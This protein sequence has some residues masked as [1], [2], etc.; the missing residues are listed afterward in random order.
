MLAPVAGLPADIRPTVGFDGSQAAA[1]SVLSSDPDLHL[2]RRATFGQTP[3]VVADIRSQG[4]TAWLDRQLNPSQIDDSAMNSLLA[5]FPMISASLAVLN[6]QTQPRLGALELVQATLARQIWSKRQLFEIMVDFW[7][8][9]LNVHT[10]ESATH[11]TKPIEDRTVTRV[12]AL[13]RFEDLLVASGRSPAML[14]YLDNADSKL[15]NPNENYGRELLQL[16]TVGAGANFTEVDV[17]NSARILTGRSVDATNTFVYKPDWHFVG[18][19]SVLGWSSS[20]ASAS[21]GLSTGDSY[22]RYL[23]RH[24][25]TARSLS[26]KLAIRFVSDTPPG[27]LVD[28]LTDVYLESGTAIVPW[29][30]ALFQS[31]EFAASTGQKMRRPL[32]DI[33]ASVRAMKLGV[34]TGND[35]SGIKLLVT[36]SAKFG[37]QPLDCGPP[38]GYPDVAAG[39]WA[40]GGMLSRCNWHRIVSRV[41]PPGL[42]RPPLNDLLAGPPMA[43]HGEMADRLAVSLTGQVFRSDHREALLAFAGLTSTQ[44]YEQRKVDRW[45]KD[46]VEL[47]LNS[48][49]LVLR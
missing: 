11:I 32:E 40:V 18:P 49:Y 7:S 6:A 15:P 41:H 31:P 47:V 23:A 20:N 29:V 26:R 42:P 3:S 17:V 44:K 8:N 39:W 13:G 19:V 14:R 33:V 5:K 30:R 9:H 37:M 43:T 38:T 2:A 36:D 4:A 28:H 24:E 21:S 35:V 45:L 27:S 48:P 34:P 25:Q 22:L 16:H 46:F 10:P 1:G 12:H